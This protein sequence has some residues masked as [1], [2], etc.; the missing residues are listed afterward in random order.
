LWHSLPNDV[1]IE[2]KSDE[3]LLE[4][5]ELN[6]ESGIMCVD[7]EIKDLLDH[8]NFLHLNVGVTQK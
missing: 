8:C 3:K 5:F 6:I 2:I 1:A 7:V 4:W